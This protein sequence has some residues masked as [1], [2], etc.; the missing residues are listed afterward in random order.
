MY[1]DMEPRVLPRRVGK[2]MEPRADSRIGDA[3]IKILSREPKA[4][5]MY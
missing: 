2:D 4:D 3:G 5:S 1:Q